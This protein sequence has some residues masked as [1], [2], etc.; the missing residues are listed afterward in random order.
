MDTQRIDYFFISKGEYF[1]PECIPMLREKLQAADESHAMML[2]S[3]EYYNPIMMLLVSLLVGEL[4][5]DR[6]LLGETGLGILKLITLGGCGVWWLIDLF[7][8]QRRTRDYNYKKFM[9]YS[10]Y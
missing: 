9:R 1:Q 6:F 7:G 8:I 2:E 3:V 4:G 10:S 5:D